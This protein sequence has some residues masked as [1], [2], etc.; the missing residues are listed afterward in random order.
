MSRTRRREWTTRSASSI[1]LTPKIADL[2]AFF[3]ALTDT[4]LQPDPPPKVPS[5]LP[6]VAVKTKATPAPQVARWRTRR[7]RSSSTSS[8]TSG[9]RPATIRGVVASPQPTAVPTTQP[10]TPVAAAPAAPLSATPAATCTGSRAWKLLPR[11]TNAERRKQSIT[12]GARGGA[13]TGSPRWAVRAA[14]RRQQSRHGTFPVRPW[15]IHS[16]GHRPLHAGRSRRGRTGRLPPDVAIDSDGVTLIGLNRDGQRAVL[17]GGGAL[18]DAVQSSADDLVVAGL[19]I[20]NYKG[21]GILASK[22]QPRRV[23]RS[24]RRK[25]R[26]V[27]RLSG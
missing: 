19:V 4:S 23:S 9:E 1:S 21:N 11:A 2:V 7:A 25:R 24:D 3:K 26:F 6:V 5:G 17:D 20:R 16:G 8:R 14:H 15:P 10:K 13:S 18:A 22:A 27:R 12:Q